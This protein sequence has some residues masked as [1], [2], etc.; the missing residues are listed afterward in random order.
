MNEQVTDLIDFIRELVEDPNVTRNIKG[1]LSEINKQLKEAT[2]EN[3]SL[4]ANKL[5][6]DLDDISSDANLD[7]FTR[8]QIWSITS[9]L[10]AL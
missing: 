3:L 8:Q 5:L 7:S 1:K 10:E 2:E 6:T 9:M 4:V